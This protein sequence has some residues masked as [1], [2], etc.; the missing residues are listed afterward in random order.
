MN[1]LLDTNVAIW[2]VGASG[3]L[4]RRAVQLL[5]D[6][7]NQIFVSVASLWEI[8]IK[9][10]LNRGRSGDLAIPPQAAVVL[11]SDAGFEI[12]P[13]EVAHVVAAANLPPIHGDP[14]DR[15]LVAQAITEPMRLMT[16]DGTL[17]Q[18]SELVILA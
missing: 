17:A 11:F 13:I 6:Q 8:S 15:L 7:S 4:S 2:A 9:Y 3:R 12:M 18:Y 5:E 10:P 14:F 1:I 16:G